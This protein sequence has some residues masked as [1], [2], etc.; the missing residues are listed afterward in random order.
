MYASRRRAR[1]TRI[2]LSGASVTAS[3]EQE[4][5]ENEKKRLRFL[6]VGSTK[7]KKRKVKPWRPF[8]CSS[9]L[10]ASVVLMSGVHV[11]VT[12]CVVGHKIC[13]SY[14]MFPFNLICILGR[15][16]DH[17][18]KQFRLHVTVGRARTRQDNLTTSP[19]K[20]MI[21]SVYVYFMMERLFMKWTCFKYFFLIILK[22]CLNYM[23][24]FV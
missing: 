9:L 7:K 16:I 10:A 8:G 14:R 3:V 20:N 19:F 1:M 2:D 17:Q 24:D 15:R 11:C 12:C 18:R 6:L 23:S 22:K 13:V 4:Q 21:F 5:E